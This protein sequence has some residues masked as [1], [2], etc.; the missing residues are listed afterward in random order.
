MS[1]EPRNLHEEEYNSYEEMA[2]DFSTSG[3]PCIE[4]YLVSVNSPWDHFVTVRRSQSEYRMQVR[5]SPN[6]PELVWS[7]KWGV[8]VP[9][10][11]NP[12]SRK[13]WE[14]WK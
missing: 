3:D 8:R 5:S 7:K 6:R 14:F 4:I 10:G 9:F 11:Q 12:I 2:K 1:T 13:W